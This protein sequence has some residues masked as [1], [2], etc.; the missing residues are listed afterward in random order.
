MT[1][2]IA[3]AAIGWVVY[4]VDTDA[5][6]GIAGPIA[7]TAVAALNLVVTVVSPRAKVAVV[8]RVQRHFV[9]PV[10]R[11][12]HRLGINPLGVALL[13]TTGRTTGLPRVTPVGVGRIGDVVWFVAEHGMRASYVRNLV[14]EPRVRIRL[15]EG[16]HQVWRDGTAR[17]HPAD[18]PLR[19]QRRLAGWHPLRWLNVAMVRFLG[20]ELLSVRIDLEPLFAPDE[21][22]TSRAV[23][24]SARH[25]ARVDA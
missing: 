11:S 8:R 24:R 19:R 23:A 20:A 14:A 18:D 5:W 9:N 13:E 25:S 10:V 15:R 17:V 1:G 3:F 7:G 4:G 12:L 22:Q 6:P 16:L 2:S 21:P